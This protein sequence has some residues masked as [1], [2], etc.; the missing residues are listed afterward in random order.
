MIN[1]EICYWVKLSEQ[2]AKRL[3]SIKN[4]IWVII[5]KLLRFIYDTKYLT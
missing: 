2:N 3:T 1:I 4:D 5:V